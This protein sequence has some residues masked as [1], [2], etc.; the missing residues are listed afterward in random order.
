MAYQSLQEIPVCWRVD[1]T[2]SQLG[3][4]YESKTNDTLLSLQ[5]NPGLDSEWS[6]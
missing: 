4:D 1:H 2:V 5:N 6:S 3:L